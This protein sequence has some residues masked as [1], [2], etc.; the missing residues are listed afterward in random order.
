MRDFDLVRAKDMFMQYIKWREEF[1]VDAIYK[2][3]KLTLF[4]MTK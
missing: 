2:V 3:I 4:Y 1:R